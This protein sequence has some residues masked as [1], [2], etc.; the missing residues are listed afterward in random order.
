VDDVVM[1]LNLD[2][3][4]AGSSTTATITTIS[5]NDITI[6]GNFGGALAVAKVIA[7]APRASAAAQQSNTY[8]YVASDQDAPPDIGTSGDRPWRWGE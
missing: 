4:D 2:G 8:V 5:G 7:Y 1:L 6:D 3:S